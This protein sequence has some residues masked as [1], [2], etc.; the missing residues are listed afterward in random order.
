[1]CSAGPAESSDSC[2]VESGITCITCHAVRAL[3]SGTGSGGYLMGTPSAMVDEKGNPISRK[4]SDESILN[5]PERHSRA[6]MQAF[7][8]TSEFCGSCHRADLP[9]SLTGYKIEREFDTYGE[10]QASSFSGQSPLSFYVTR[11]ATCQDCHMTREPHRRSSVGSKTW[12]FASH[13]WLAGNTAIPF[14][15]GYGD[16]LDQT[17]RYLKSGN[18]LDIDIF[19]IRSSAQRKLVAP[20]GVVPLHIVQNDIVETFLIIENKGVGHSLLPEL[21]DLYEGWVEFLVKDASGKEIFHSGFLKPDGSLDE[22]AHAFVNRPIDKDGEFV[23]NHE[24]W[25]I[26]STGY[27]STIPA[28]R[29]I[30]VRYRFHIPANLEGP[31]SITASV[32]YR[33]FRQSY[34]S[35]VL[36][37]DHP[38]YPIVQLASRTIILEIGENRPQ[39]VGPDD[40]PAWMRWNNLG[41]AC[42][43][44]GSGLAPIPV[45]EY[46]QAIDAF[47]EVLK[48]RPLYADGYTNLAL[49]YI[50]LGKFEK[51]AT[52]LA[53]ALALKPG[54]SRALYYRG[55]VEERTNQDVR[56][57]ADFKKVVAIFPR[58]RDARRELGTVELA[59]HQYEDALQQFQALQQ[60]DPDDLAAHFNLAILYRHLGMN[61]EAAEQEVLYQAQK[62]D[63]AAPTYSFE[64]LRT[65][66]EMANEM[67]PWHVHTEGLPNGSET[68][69]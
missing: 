67:L 35:T 21:R 34:L 56:A 36:G 57:L 4:V 49:T 24:V 18:Y 58:S 13:R 26:R 62:P 59:Q 15:Y 2:G 54:N 40:N 11:R 23:D 10:W 37:A 64:Y 66:P 43:D 42:L 33:H 22:S 29:S 52:L 50:Q 30:L 51:A 63:P 55:L 1:M 68:A 19:G 16:Q 27:D 39:P 69:H 28:G 7:Y 41:I 32:N 65:H 5:S 3:T 12:T 38:Q 9:S 25:K 44:R 46:A 17:T 61:S 20:L 8:K 48:L 53:R 60:M 14:L 47:S 31:V 6:V 45:E